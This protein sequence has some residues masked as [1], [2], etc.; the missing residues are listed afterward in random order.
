MVAI[1]IASAV[2][3][4]VTALFYWTKVSSIPLTDGIENKEEAEKLTK[5]T[6]SLIHI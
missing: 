3:G 4:L 6:L 1:I 2:L 5:I